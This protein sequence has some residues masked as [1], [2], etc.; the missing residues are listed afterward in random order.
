[1]GTLDIEVG[2]SAIKIVGVF[3]PNAFEDFGFLCL[4]EFSIDDRLDIDVGWFFDGGDVVSK[5]CLVYRYAVRY[6]V[7]TSRVVPMVCDVGDEVGTQRVGYDSI[8][9]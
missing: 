9:A 8:D 7:K 4:G 3:G 5:D 2:A 1:M 6:V